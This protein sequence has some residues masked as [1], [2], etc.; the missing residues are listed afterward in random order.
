MVVASG[1]GQ[2][3][4]DLKNPE[5]QLEKLIKVGSMRDRII[6]ET[7]PVSLMEFFSHCSRC[8]AYGLSVML[9]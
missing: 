4:K 3:L 1:M 7:M 8:I 5:E 6:A 2:Y 9:L